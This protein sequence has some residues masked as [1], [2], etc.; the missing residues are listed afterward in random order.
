[1]KKIK[2]YFNISNTNY[3]MFNKDFE[4]AINELQNDGQ[5]VEVQYQTNAF[6]NEQIAYSALILGRVEQ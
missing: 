6:S 3:D 5:E 4:N 1:M 2:G